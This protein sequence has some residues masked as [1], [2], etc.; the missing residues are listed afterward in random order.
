MTLY[1]SSMYLGERLFPFHFQLVSSV[2]IIPDVNVQV[3]FFF[4]H[5]LSLIFIFLLPYHA[6]TNIFAQNPILHF[7]FS[8]WTN[9]LSPEAYPLEFQ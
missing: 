8:I 5:F 7:R 9:F 4:L 1:S 2:S 6:F 3:L